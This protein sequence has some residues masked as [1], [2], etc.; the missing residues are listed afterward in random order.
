MGL[1]KN[2]VGGGEPIHVVVGI[3]LAPSCNGCPNSNGAVR[4]AHDRSC[5]AHDGEA[6]KVW[7]LGD[8]PRPNSKLKG[9]KSLV[10][11]HGMRH[12]FPGRGML[13]T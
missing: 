13:R 11:G 7:D 10:Y 5:Q 6:V 8:R 3:R 1:T 12:V 2:L 9:H 4:D